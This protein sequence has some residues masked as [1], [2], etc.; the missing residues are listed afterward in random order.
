MRS[1]TDNAGRTWTLAINV[2]AIKR[3]RGLLEVDLLEVVEGKLI[4]RFIRDPVLL[5]D[6][7]Y[8]VCK[9]EADAKGVSDEEF[10][11]AMAGDAIEHATKALLEELVGF[12]P[13]P[14]D[15]A[16]LQRVLE[17]TWTAMDRARDVVEARL[18][19]GEL[20]RVVEQALATATN[21]S[22]GAPA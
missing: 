16:N 1:F 19:S 12:S 2:G 7:V 4:E 9:P 22:G 13:S 8:A 14:R 18:T 20:D 10:G 5:C 21:S 15:R 3:V 6:V 11:K 17:A